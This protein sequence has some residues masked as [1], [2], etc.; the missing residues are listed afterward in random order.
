M[1]SKQ[2]TVAKWG[3]IALFA[4]A[5]IL[6]FFWMGKIDINYN[7]ASYLG[8]DTQTKIALDII[9]DEF[10]MTGN[11]QV[12]AQNVTTETAETIQKTIEQIPHVIKV[13]FDKYSQTSYK[14]GNALFIVMVEGDD[15]ST[16]AKQVAADIQS[17]L[18]SY[19]NMQY[20]G[21]TV[22]KQALQE[23]ITSEMVYI[24]AI[25]LCLVVVI[26]LVTSESWLE[27][28]I[29]LA[30]SGVAVLINRGTNIIF[31][32]I[33]YITNS[34][35]AI[36]QL[37]L[38]IDYSI[39][40]LHTYRREKEKMGD[41]DQAML[42][43]IR[44]VTRPVSASALTTIAGLLA[45]LFMS[46]RIGFDIGIVLMKG[47]FI[48]AVTSLTLLPVLILLLDTPMR[49]T[50]KKAFIP[51]GHS[52]CKIAIKASKTIIPIA[53]VLIILCGI[54]QSNNGYLFTDT[55][56]GNSAI[57]EVFGSNNSVVLVYKR[58]ENDFANEQKLADH[59]AAYRTQAG[60]AVL[61][62]YTAYSNTVRQEYDIDT[63]VQKLNVPK[64][65]AQMLFTMYNLYQ[66]P[67]DIQMTFAQFIDYT[68]D[69]VKTDE[70]TGAFMDEDTVQALETVQRLSQILPNEFTAEDLHTMLTTGPMEG[71]ELSLFSVRQLYGMYFYESI[72]D[73]QVDF[74]T[75]LH[76]L[77]ESADNK[78]L[79]GQ[80]DQATV[81]HLKRLANAVD[82][83]NLFATQSD[84]LSQKINAS[85]EYQDFLTALSQIA[86]GLS[87]KDAQ[88][89][90]TAESMQ[91]I[92]ILY[93]Y[94]TG[95]LQPGKMNGKDF[96]EYA[97]MQDQT[98]SVIHD[99]L[100]DDNRNKLD[101]MLTIGDYL[102]NS[103]AMTYTQ[104]CNTLTQLQDQIKSGIAS[105]ALE[106][107]KISGVFIKYAVNADAPLSTPMMAYELLDFVVENMDSNVLLKEMMTQENRDMVLQ[108]QTDIG[109]ANTLFL[110]ENYGRMLLSIDL[111]S[112]SE[113]TLKFVEYLSAEAKLIFGEEACITG[114]IVSTYDLQNSFSY[115]NMF[116]TIFT[117]ISIFV[118][119]M[120]IFKSL[121]LPVILV[122]IIQGAIFIAMSTQLLTDGIFFMSYIVST[123]ILMGA[124]IDYGIL[125]SSNYIAYRNTNDRETALRL[126]VE[127][128]MPTVFSSGMILV[129]CGFVINFI[130][131][132]N[133][134]STVGLLIG[135]GTLCSVA[136]ITIV[137][138]SALYLLDRFVLK[139]TLPQ[140]Q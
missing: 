94:E 97:K 123:C 20:G 96:V 105:A 72:A 60:Q 125:M 95:A 69:L 28:L 81:I 71:T 42:E 114:E 138:P 76:F 106:D 73:Q 134:I 1:N 27:P 21:T 52:C 49:K 118:I 79:E 5:M 136:M 139:L 2:L 61:S 89:N 111:P 133:S 128:A 126:S 24:L 12:M 64:E 62:N 4:V 18:A 36:L 8:K 102:S 130:S 56:G 109:K 16:N 92:Y 48:S 86:T 39:V 120:I 74:K 15:Y 70:D 83:H 6:S 41:N 38:S 3:V 37:A 110:S 32:E 117:L 17:A 14:N 88:I 10:G 129:I 124:T 93:F 116:I 140:K 50:Q 75:M 43:A 53:M 77:I 87:G 19:E 13:S 34:I 82:W 91:Q 59:V 45:L 107:E 11:I 26:L 115:D 44:T 33:S 35:A 67:T 113:E 98:N 22:I 90:A 63:A 119:V 51:M 7:L 80:F 112:E 9:E 99:Q 29:L 65:T 101:D 25:S 135:I 55:K 58:G 122:T 121:S 100:S 131:S 47:I 104:I 31:G 40:L 57:N 66:T 30:A 54:F 23:A 137:L 127:A 132:Q 108:A 68:C 103:Q 84:P 46:F 78:D 85:Y